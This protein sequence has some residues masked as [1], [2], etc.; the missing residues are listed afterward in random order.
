MDNELEIFL[1]QQ[2]RAQIFTKSEKN[3]KSL[4]T[5]HI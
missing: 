5:N 2:V 4:T 3:V 1:G